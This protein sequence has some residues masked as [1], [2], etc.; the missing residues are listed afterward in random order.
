M[1]VM[2]N[3]PDPSELAAELITAAER[4]A[5]IEPFSTRYGPFSAAQASAIRL[6]WLGQK[7]ASG[8][9]PVGKKIGAVHRRWQ[10]RAQVLEP[11]WGYILDSTLLIDSTELPFSNLIQPR[12]EAEFAFLLARDLAGPGVTAAHAIT[13]I[14]GVCA[15]FEVIDSRFEPKAPTTEDATADNSSHAYAV[16]GTRLISP[17]DRDLASA[18][19]RLEINEALQ[20]TGS[21]ANIVGN[22]LHALVALANQ[23]ALRAG[24]IILTGSVAGAFPVH[25]GDQVRAVFDG[26]GTIRLGVQ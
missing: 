4:S 22:P 1:G 24:E 2:P 23:Q 10:S 16:I 7:V 5:P 14:A 9:R 8:H 15:A 19:V 13:A 20:G 12:I 26:L 17:F 11:G 6:A 3:L 21:G 18:S 25:P